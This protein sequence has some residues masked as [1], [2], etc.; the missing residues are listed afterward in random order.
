VAEELSGS[1]EHFQKHSICPYCAMLEQELESDS[2]VVMATDNFVLLCPYASRFPF[3]MCLLPRRH[4][5]RFEEQSTDELNE[6]AH[7]L[8]EAL[9]RLGTVLDQPAYNYYL[10]TAPLHEG[11][12]RHYHWHMEIF[13]RLAQL[14]GFELGGGMFINPVPPEQAARMLA[15]GSRR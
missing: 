6:L 9:S 10:H 4:A 8:K 11:Q 2:R 1:K 12:L 7:V 15:V 13:P 5:S 3:E 14:A